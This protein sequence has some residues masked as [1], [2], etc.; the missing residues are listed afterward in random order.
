MFNN[1]MLLN[2]IGFVR[3]KYEKIVMSM[4]VKLKV[5]EVHTPSRLTYNFKSLFCV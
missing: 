1:A 2:N 4:K 3:K 5:Q